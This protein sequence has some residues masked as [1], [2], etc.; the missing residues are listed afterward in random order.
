MSSDSRIQPA[1]L[2]LNYLGG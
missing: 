2:S 1:H